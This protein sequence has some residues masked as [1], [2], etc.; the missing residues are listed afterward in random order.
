MGTTFAERLGQVV[1]G[2]SVHAFSKRA[3]ISDSTFRQYLNGTMPGLDKL[4]QIADA[5]GVTLD[6][7][8]TGKGPKQTGEALPVNSGPSIVSENSGYALVPRLDIQPSA[9]TGSVIY[10][11][12]ALDF[13]AFQTD[14]LK[15]R[16]IRPDYARVLTARGDSMME[17]IHDGDALLVDTSINRFKD[18]A[19]YVL[20][21]GSM[22]LVKRIHARMNGSVQ[23]ISDNPRYPPEEITQGEIDQLHIAGRVMWFGRSI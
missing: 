5:G 15:A 17:T 13:L 19:I 14:W 16:G 21:Y 18:N 6:W 10:T 7:L 12:D 20:V 8:A 1:D 2:E 22:V 9:G 4:I 23:L 11:E 3:G